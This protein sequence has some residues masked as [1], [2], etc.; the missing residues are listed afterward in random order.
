MPNSTFSPEDLLREIISI[1]DQNP[2]FVYTDQG[3]H[4]QGYGHH[5]LC[6]YLGRALGDP[7]G[8]PCIVGRA[9]SNLGVPDEELRGFEGKSA[10]LV[11]GRASGSTYVY[12]N[13]THN[14]ISTAVGQIQIHQD[15]GLPWS[16]CVAPYRQYLS[17]HTK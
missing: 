3:A 13:N 4:P 17:E 11:M 2:D 8:S 12:D 5:I 14:F 7:T 16:E 15:N 1:A 6:S 9:L 10:S